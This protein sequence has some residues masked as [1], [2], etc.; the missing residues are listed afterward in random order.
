MQH[1]RHGDVVGQV[2]GQLARAAPGLVVVNLGDVV[3][4]DVLAV[5]VALDV[6]EQIAAR[7]RPGVVDVT[8]ET[9]E[10]ATGEAAAGVEYGLAVVGIVFRENGVDMAA[11]CR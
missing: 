6:A 10:D 5:A 9:E 1:G 2:V 11:R 3:G 8:V 7:Y 4:R